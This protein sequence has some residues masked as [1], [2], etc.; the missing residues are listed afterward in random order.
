MWN[1]QKLP[2]PRMRRAAVLTACV[3]S[4]GAATACV[5]VDCDG[6]WHD[7]YDHHDRDRGDHRYRGGDY[8]GNYGGDCDRDDYACR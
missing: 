1:K 4:F 7:G 8:H 6:C 3:L 2:L 5:P